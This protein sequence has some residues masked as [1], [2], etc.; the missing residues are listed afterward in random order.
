[1][2]QHVVVFGQ[3][4][5]AE[6][7]ADLRQRYDLEVFL[8]PQHTDREAFL[9]ALATADGLL[10]ANLPVDARLLRHAP[11][12][13]VIA[14]VSA[15]YDNYDLAE[16]RAR[17]IVLTHTPDAVTETTADTGFMLLMMTAR[18]AVELAEH[19]Q[20]GH[21]T[22]SI[23]ASMFGLDVHGKRLGIIGLGRIGAALARRAHLGFAMKIVYTGNSAKPRQEAELGATRRSLDELLA[24]ADFVAVCV[25][26]TPATHHLIGARELA[27]MRPDTIFINI[28]RGPVVDEAALVEALRAGQLRA[29]GLDVFAVEPLPAGSPLRGMPNVVALPHIGSATIEARA[30]MARTAAND[31]IAVLAGRAPTYPVPTA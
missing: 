19:V 5:S 27:R 4:S 29:A 23:G 22:A 18:R 16:L 28:S 25:P 13:R 30:L 1:M 17:G 15:G 3:V 14:S 24:E 2:K 6:V 21:W 7:M 11:R 12:L 31:L 20:R 8:D 26:L 9:T 10:G